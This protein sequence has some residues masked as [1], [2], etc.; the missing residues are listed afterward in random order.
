[1]SKSLGSTPGSIIYQLCDLTSPLSLVLNNRETTLTLPTSQGCCEVLI[2]ICENSLQNC[3]V[4]CN[5][6]KLLMYLF[7]DY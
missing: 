1:M 6:K 2:G 7:R 4:V 5:S 3:K